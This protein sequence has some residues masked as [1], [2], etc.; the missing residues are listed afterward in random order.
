MAAVTSEQLIKARIPGTGRLIQGGVEE[1]EV[2]Y[3]GTMAFWDSDGY[4]TPTAGG[5]RFAG[6][7]RKT[8][9]NTAGGDGAIQAELY[10][11]GDFVLPMASAATTDITPGLAYA[12]DNYTIT[13]TGTSNSFVGTIIRVA[14]TNLVEVRIDIQDRPDEVGGS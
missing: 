13:T 7:V 2:L 11:E 10:T 6:I 12:T 14:G 1:G 8:V 5:N 4:L 9:D 3:G